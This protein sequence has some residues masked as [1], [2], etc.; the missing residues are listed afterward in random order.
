MGI[1]KKILLL[2]NKIFPIP[3]EGDAE[4]EDR[5]DLEI[6][7]IIN[8]YKKTE[9]LRNILSSL[10]QQN[11]DKKNFE[12]LLIEDKSGT[13]EGENLAREF[14]KDLNIRYFKL[15]KNYGA[16]GYARNFGLQKSIG[17]YILFLDDDTVILQNNFL[18]NLIHEFNNSDADC[19]MPR[20]F[21]SYCLIKNRY[22]YHD[23]YFPTNRCVAY[24]RT[25]LTELKG[26]ISSII[27]QEDV[28]FTIRLILSRKKLMDSQKLEYFHPPL[29]QNNLTK[30]A[31]VGLSFSKLRKRYPFPI[32][33]L[34]LIN[35]CRYLPL[36][37]LPLNEKLRNQA[38]FSIGFLIGIIYSIIGKKTNYS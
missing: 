15:D 34:L 11:F 8:F 18:E 23:P 7:C 21:A 5:S 10:K 12:V 28:E 16:M 1:R 6:S 29:V 13:E 37:I 24:K 35:G 36:A 33:I 26:F 20:G 30:S 22:D 14:S 27:G 9:L 4:I 3:L 32:W 17:K 19:I 38:R 2:I 25:T 31:A